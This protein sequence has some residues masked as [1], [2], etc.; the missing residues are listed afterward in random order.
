MLA[1][2]LAAFWL[3]HGLADIVKGIGGPGQAGRVWR[4]AG[5]VIGLIGEVV[6]LS[7]PVAAP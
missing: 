2:V 5:D 6:R 1:I 4:I 7:A 3:I